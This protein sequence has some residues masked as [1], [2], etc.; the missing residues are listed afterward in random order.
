MALRPTLSGSLPFSNVRSCFLGIH[1]THLTCLQLCN[2]YA[3][4]YATYVP[5]KA[6]NKADGC[7][8][9]VAVKSVDYV[10]YR[11]VPVCA[12]NTA[13][14]R[15]RDIAQK[16]DLYY[17][18]KCNKKRPDR[19]MGRLLTRLNR[20]GKELKIGNCEEELCPR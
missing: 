4:W 7:R 19:P 5:E 20:C 18:Q 15:R 17:L 2:V 13:E 8:N 3:R 9:F 14:I 16:K 10:D 1:R 6:L 11:I 12:D